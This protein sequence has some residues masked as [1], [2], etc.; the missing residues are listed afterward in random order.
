MN[1][2]FRSLQ[3][4]DSLKYEF[5]VFQGFQRQTAMRAHFQNEHVGGSHDMVKA[6]PLCSY[7]AGSMKSLRVHF[8]SRHGIDLDNPMPHSPSLQSS[9]NGGSGSPGPCGSGNGEYSELA[10]ALGFED[11]E[12]SSDSSLIPSHFLVP[13]IE[14]S[15]NSPYPAHFSFTADSSYNFAQDER[16]S[17]NYENRYDLKNPDS[18]MARTF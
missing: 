11:R 1:I 13:Q 2:G 9:S 10:H 12:K 15:S 5:I 4:C 17:S 6:C 18:V 7:K 3:N 14:I 16:H 8:Y